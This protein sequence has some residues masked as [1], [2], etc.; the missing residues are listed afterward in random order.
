VIESYFAGTTSRLDGLGLDVLAREAQ[1]KH[2]HSLR[3]VTEFETS[4]R[5]EARTTSGWM[6]SITC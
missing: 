1:V 3:P 4:L 2:E 6:A 5:S